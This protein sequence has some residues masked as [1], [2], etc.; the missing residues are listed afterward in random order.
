MVLAMDLVVENKIFDLWIYSIAF[1][2]LIGTGKYILNSMIGCIL[3]QDVRS[4]GPILFEL[5]LTSSLYYWMTDYGKKFSIITFNRT[6]IRNVAIVMMSLMG[7]IRFFIKDKYYSKGWE[8]FEKLGGF[9]I[10]YYGR[11]WTP[12]MQDS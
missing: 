5:F 6:I 2:T 3:K 11:T 12:H 8:Q 1:S 10:P 9:F 7:L 4:F